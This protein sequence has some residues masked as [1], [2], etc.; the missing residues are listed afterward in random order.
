MRKISICVLVVA[1]LLVGNSCGKEK[2]ITMEPQLGEMRAICE[3]ATMDC[4]YHNVAKYKVENAEQFLWWTKDKHLW[5]EYEGIVTM[6]IDASLLSIKVNDNQVAI[7][8]PPATVLESKV[9]N[10]LTKDSF[11]TAK[12]SAGITAEDEIKA[13]QEAQMDMRNTAEEDKALLAS[14]QERAKKLLENYVNNIGG[15][16]GIE[17][18][19]EWVYVDENGNRIN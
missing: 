2:M 16:V 14:A 5:I 10:S 17:Y 4:Y 7:T 3:L 12:G 6:G 9:E 15:V 1:M 8:I 13:F 19:I 11:I 18:D